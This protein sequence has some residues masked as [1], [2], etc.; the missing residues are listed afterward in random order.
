VQDFLLD[1]NTYAYMNPIFQRNQNIPILHKNE[2]STDLVGKKALA[3]LDDAAKN[4]DSPFFL[5]I[6]PIAPHANFELRVT[7]DIK[8]II[9]SGNL[10]AGD[11][12]IGIVTSP[13]VSAA[14]HSHL[15]PDAIVPR[16]PNFN[17]EKPSGVDW[18]ADTVRL[19]AENIT[20]NDLW[21]RQ[22]L[23]S[24]QAVDEI[25]DQVIA[26]L[27]A[28]GILDNTYI[29][30]TADNGYHIGQHRLQPGKG[31]GIEEDINVPLVVRGPGVPQGEI[32]NF[33]TSHTDLAP[34]FFDMMGIPLRDDFDGL[35][36]PT[37]R[38]S[39]NELKDSGK[40]KE[41]VQIEFWS[42]GNPGEYN[43]NESANVNNTYKGLRIVAEEYGFYYSVWCSGSHEL[44][45]MK[46]SASHAYHGEQRS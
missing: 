10:S 5:T 9:A 41:H 12:P 37:T 27:E 46:V 21:Y 2:Y 1:P 31:C 24:L 30:Y 4:P 15:F 20:F 33:A 43:D 36:I 13:P 8:E 32:V 35:P 44:Y 3:F 7:S 40:A 19:S 42:T 26:K 23:R 18:I 38:Q 22:R 25:V 11:P 28:Y 39:I 16:T 34:T 45:D 29:V 17:P 6:T 14:R